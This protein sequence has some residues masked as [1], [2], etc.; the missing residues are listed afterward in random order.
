MGVPDHAV[1]QMRVVKRQLLVHL[2]GRTNAYKTC[3]IG[4]I[5]VAF[6]YVSTNR[7]DNAI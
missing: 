2:D 4:M 1:R 3:E 6:I 7:N 5:A